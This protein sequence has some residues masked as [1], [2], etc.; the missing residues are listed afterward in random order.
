A[1]KS[2][3]FFVKLRGIA[4]TLEQGVKQLESALRQEDEDYEEEPPL[5]VLNDLHCEIASLKED[6]DASLHKNCSEK[7]EISAFIK[8]TETLMQRNASE[9]ENISELFKK[10]CCKTSVEDSTAVSDQNKPDEEKA[11]DGPHL[12]ASAEMLPVPEDPLHIPQLSDFGLSQYAFSRPLSAVK[13][14][15]ATSAHQENSDNGAFLK[16]QSPGIL[17]KTPE[18]VLSMYDYDCTTPRLEHFG[19]SEHTMCMNDDFTMSLA[20]KAVEASKNQFKSTEIAY[21]AFSETLHYRRVQYRNSVLYLALAI[22]ALQA[23]TSFVSSSLLKRHLWIF[24]VSLLFLRE[25]NEINIPEMTPRKAI[26][27]PVPKS[28]A[29]ADN[30][31]DWMVSPMV[32][33]FCTPDVK[34]PSRTYRTLPKTPE[35]NVLP[36]PTHMQTPQLP[37]FETGWLKTE[38]MVVNSNHVLFNMFYHKQGKLGEGTE[39]VMKNNRPDEKPIKDVRADGRRNANYL[40]HVEDPSPPE[41]KY[42]D[43]LLSTPPT[44][45][46]TMIPDDVLQIMSKYSRK[47]DSSVAKKME[48]KAGSTTKYGNYFDC[49]KENRYD[50]SL[51]DL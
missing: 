47:A 49:N 20:R 42:C 30:A 51:T 1:K 43:Q 32:L 14:R 12:P 28:K 31:S 8:A 16:R 17:P 37:D 9:L 18:R 39:S 45:E 24:I 36:L 6:I 7:Q 41:I 26:V 3:E 40:K 29:T 13:G 46:I 15:H 23:V 11:D 33:V 50:L 44:P 10:Y 25:D 27:T 48:T 4:L 34:T 19:I 21:K 22:L 38:V 2:R 35:R 5:R